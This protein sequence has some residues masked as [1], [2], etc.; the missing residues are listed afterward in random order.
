MSEIAKP[1]LTHL[2]LMLTYHC[3]M[4]CAMCGQV[5][6]KRRI[7]EYAYLPLEMIKSQI[8]ECHDLKSVYLFGG[9]PL[10]YPDFDELVKYLYEKKLTIIIT[11]NGLEINKHIDSIV[12]YVTDI[13]IS[14]DSNIKADFE[15]IRSKNTYDKVMNNYRLLLEECKK[16]NSNLQIGLNIVI[17]KENCRYL[18]ELNEC[19]YKDVDKI[20]RINYEVPITINSYVGEKY[21]KIC[22]GQFGVKADSWTWFCNKLKKFTKEEIDKIEKAVRKLK[23]YPKVTFLAPASDLKKFLLNEEN[24]SNPTCRFSYHSCSI[25]PNGDVTF[26]VDFPDYILGSICT[27]N[28]VS[29]FDNKRACD[30]RKYF[31]ENGNLPICQR[32][33]RIFNNNNAISTK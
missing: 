11:T 7:K 2:T 18:S 27:D 23:E 31:E 29:I 13:S 5:Y 9:E 22:D 10:L 19:F 20:N 14:I 30:F 12:N 25:L 21:Q 8:E 4:S 3:N 28:I 1:L 33:P 17:M 16:R 32:C 26:C 24:I 15:S 6:S